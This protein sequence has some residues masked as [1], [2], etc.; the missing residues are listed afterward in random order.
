MSGTIEAEGAGAEA[1][2]DGADAA[3][4]EAARLGVSRSLSRHAGKARP[5][6]QQQKKVRVE[7]DMARH[8]RQRAQR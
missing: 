3:T 8:D 1:D 4:E 6:A 7:R 2:A 5:S